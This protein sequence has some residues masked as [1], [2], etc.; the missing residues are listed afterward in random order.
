MQKELG[1]M[2]DNIVMTTMKLGANS[3][4]VEEAQNC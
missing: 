3:S 2:Q 4:N 1:I